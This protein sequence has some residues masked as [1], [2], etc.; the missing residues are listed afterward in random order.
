MTTLATP[1]F[2]YLQE[3]FVAPQHPS[4]PGVDTRSG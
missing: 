4:L 3:A 2:L 1:P